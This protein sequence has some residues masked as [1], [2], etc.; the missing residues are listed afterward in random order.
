MAI[1]GLIVLAI[2][3][4]TSDRGAVQGETDNTD[5][6]VQAG[7]P[8]ESNGPATEPVSAQGVDTFFQKK[9]ADICSEDGKP[10]V[11]LFSTTWCLHCVWVK[12]AFDEIVA[13]YVKAGK[14]KAHH[15]E[16]D[17]GDDV[18]T[19]EEETQVPESALAVYQEFNPGGSI[20]TFVFGCKYFRVGNG[21]EQQDDL[22]AEKEE[23]QAVIEDLIK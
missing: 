20:P 7:T 9:G 18:L 2:V 1:I 10:V 21:F 22:I 14:I 3:M 11:Y 15:Y 5:Q 4:M 6:D 23:F 16:L 17:I 12:D 13:E 19:S 8:P